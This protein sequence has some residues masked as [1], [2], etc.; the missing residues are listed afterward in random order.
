MEQ[1]PYAAQATATFWK[2]GRKSFTRDC[3]LIYTYVPV[4]VSIK[5]RTVEN[6][7]YQHAVT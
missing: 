3:E 1:R 5:E 4:S 6:P 2:I 7:N